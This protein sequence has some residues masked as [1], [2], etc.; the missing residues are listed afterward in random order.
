MQIGETT[1]RGKSQRKTCDSSLCGRG[2][3]LEHR[4]RRL[5]GKMNWV[6]PTIKWQNWHSVLAVVP[7]K[8]LPSLQIKE[9]TPG[10]TVPPV[11]L[12]GHSPDQ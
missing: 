7:A 5:I 3:K 10:C 8:V 11:P 6:N 4:L 2:E 12:P 1:L 9:P